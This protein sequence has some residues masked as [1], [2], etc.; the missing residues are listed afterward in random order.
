MLAANA[1]PNVHDKSGMT[2]LMEAAVVGN[3][4]SVKL[5]LSHGARL[6]EKGPKGL[7]ELML[8]CRY[9]KVE[10]IK[11]LLE[12]KLTLM[13]KITKALPL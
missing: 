8:A 7:S 11:T 5:L 4:R 3:V 1:D 10:A 12:T 6:N 13:L 2:P 9:G